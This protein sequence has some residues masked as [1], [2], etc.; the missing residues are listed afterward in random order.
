V[1]TFGFDRWNVL[2]YVSSIS[3]F[4]CSISIV[5][6]QRR[7]FPLK[8]VLC[9]ISVSILVMVIFSNAYLLR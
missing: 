2:S 1:N 9:P 5:V 7:I 3:F 6:S 8:Y 4:S